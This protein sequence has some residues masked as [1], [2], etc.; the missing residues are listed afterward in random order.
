MEP[1]NLKNSNFQNYLEQN[2]KICDFYS[3]WNCQGKEPP[4]KEIIKKL[5]EINKL[6]PQRKFNLNAKEKNIAKK[7]IGNTA[8]E[9]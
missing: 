7:K 1:I 8:K 4:P 6:K 9:S 3:C 2:E 5:K